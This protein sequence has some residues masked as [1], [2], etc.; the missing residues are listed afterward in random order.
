[1]QSKF[2]RRRIKNV[3]VT[4]PS[5]WTGQEL[6][7]YKAKWQK[8]IDIFTTGHLESRRPVGLGGDRPNLLMELDEAV[9]SQLPVVYGEIHKLGNIGENW[10]EL[11]GR[12]KGIDSRARIMNL[13]IGGGTSDIA[14]IEYHDENPGPGV[15]L[16]TELLFKD[17]STTA[18]DVLVRRAIEAV[19]LPAIRTGL[20]E[21]PASR[22]DRLLSAAKQDKAAQWNRVTRQ[23]FIPIIRRWL[24]DLTI[25]QYNDGETGAPPSPVVMLNDIG[26]QRVKELNDICASELAVDKVL[27]GGHPLYYDVARLRL[28][29]EEVF[30][31]F[32]RSLA[33]IAESFDCDL[34]IV[35]GKPSEL[36]SVRG[37][38]QKAIPLPR[39]RILFTHNCDVG[40]WYPLSS[41]GRIHDAKTVTV[42]GAALYQAIKLSLLPNW[43]INPTKTARF[44][45]R[46]FWGIMPLQGKRDF[47]SV[48]LTPADNKKTVSLMVNSRIGRR[49]LPTRSRPDP[50]YRIR[51]SAKGRT[52]GNEALPIRVTF[53]RVVPPRDAE[54][55]DA[56]GETLII[57]SV[58]AKRGGNAVA[59]EDL[60][61]QL[62]TL[63]NDDHWIDSSIFHI[64]IKK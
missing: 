54:G 31:D 57:S 12:G 15:V 23:V 38:L 51:W 26:G 24:S 43:V 59:L 40:A 61:L 45:G 14:V 34:L 10:I 35:S 53:E 17:S 11:I 60:E 25:G 36:P 48:I 18:G 56:V 1:M 4:Y 55:I 58:D 29:I 64:D 33:K 2:V 47:D 46:N 41:D 21:E 9:A 13:D 39:C 27:D 62:C 22:F 44:F 49:R 32:F 6:G 37:L 8:A 16:N 28:C 7:A 63:D 19:L 5:G 3:L 50:V 20:M 52:L 42:A 30:G